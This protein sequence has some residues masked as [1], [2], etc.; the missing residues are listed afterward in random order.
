MHNYKGVFFAVLTLL[1]R[2]VRKISNV[3]LPLYLIDN[4]KKI[5]K[6]KTEIIVSF[7]SFYDRINHVWQVVEFKLCQTC[8]SKK[9]C[10]GN[11]FLQ[12]I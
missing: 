12:K 7:T 4:K 11:N 6:E 8:Q 2:Q 1:R 10:F 5:S 9:C 3:Q